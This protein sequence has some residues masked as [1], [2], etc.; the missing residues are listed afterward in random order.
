MMEYDRIVELTDS[1]NTKAYSIRYISPD[2]SLYY[3]RQADRQ[4][5]LYTDGKCEALNHQMFCHFLQMDYEKVCRLYE[6]IRNL[7]NNQI[8]LL[9][10]E[11]N[12]MML[13][14]KASQNRFYYYHYNRALR[15]LERI[16]EEE[17]EFTDRYKERLFYAETEFHLVAA[18]YYIYTMQEQQAVFEL[19]LIDEEGCI[20]KDKALLSRLYYLKGLAQMWDIECEPKKTLEA[21]DHLSFA[22]SQA[23]RSGKMTYL[24]AQT[25]QSL[26]DF[27][28]EPH[29]REIAEQSRTAAF[30]FLYS[31]SLKNDTVDAD[32]P[33]ELQ[34][35]MA[36]ARKG[37]SDAIQCDNL[38]LIANGYY[39][40]GNLRFVQEEYD[41]ALEDYET[42]LS[43]INEHHS[44]YYPNDRSGMLSASRTDDS[45]SVDM[46]WAKD[47]DVQTVPAWLASLRER[48]SATYSALNNKPE[49]DYH[50]NIYLDLLDFTRQDKSLEM[51]VEQV[52]Q[53]NRILNIVLISVIL[54]TVVLTV[55]I[56]YYARLWHKRNLLR[57]N[58]LGDVYSRLKNAM[59]DR[60]E[61]QLNAVLDSYNWMKPEN[62]ILHEVLQ[63]YM[64]WT[65]WNR[66]LS[67]EMDEERTQLRM[68]LMRCERQITKNKRKNISKRAKVSLVYS[69][70]PFIDRIL[71]D[72]HRMKQTRQ[73]N[74]ETLDYIRE[75]T[76]KINAYNDV[77]VE[78]IQMNRGQLE[79]T[80]ESF[81]LQ[82][83]LGLLYKSEYSFHKK[84]L[85]L[86]VHPT[87][88]WVK[89][90]KA[91]TFFMV[92]T[93]ADNARKFTPSGGTVTVSACELD[94]SVEIRVEDTGCGLS[95]E[96]ID[97]ILS[98]KIYDAGKIG[99]C[100]GVAKEEKGSGFG[101]LN[102]K[103]IIE[104]YK[105]SGDMFRVCRF[106]ITSQLGKGS[107]FSFR[108]PKGMKGWCS[109]VVGMLL[110]TVPV[111]AAGTA[112]EHR[113]ERLLKTAVNYADSVY[114]ANIGG[115]Y[116]YTMQM[117]DSTLKYIN[118]A[119]HQ[120]LP[121]KCRCRE[122]TRL[123]DTA[124]ELEW[125]N[126]EVDADY[127][128]IM[129]LR[130]E[131]AVAALALHDWEVYE[132]NNTH[133]TH[134]YKLLSQDSS[135]EEFYTRQRE[136]RMNLN[137]GIASLIVLLLVFL[138]LIFVIHFRRRLLFRFNV[139]QVLEVHRSMLHIVRKYDHADHI[140][141]IFGELLKVIL[142]EL[143][144][145]HETEGVKI[146]FY[147]NISNTT[148]RLSEGY[149]PHVELTDSH[150]ERCYEKKEE[151]YD[152]FINTQVYPLKVTWEGNEELCI[153]AFAVN[154]GSYRMQK[155]DVIL[156][157]YIIG[158]LSIL[159]YEAVICRYR[160]RENMELAETEK[161][162]AV[163]EENRLRVQNQIL[164]NCLSTIKHESM[165]YP[166][167]I[168]QL[169]CSIDA[170][171]DAQKRMEKIHAL[172]EVAEYYKEIYTLLCAQA[173]RQLMTG[174]FKCEAVDT[175]ILVETWL[176]RT[177]RLAEKKQI[178]VTP[179]ADNEDET[180]KVF[181]DRV[182]IDYM[183]ETLTNECLVRLK[184]TGK[185][186]EL[187]LIIAKD[188][189]FIRFTLSASGRLFDA[190]QTEGLFYPDTTHY[191]YLLCKQIIREH[192][193]LN[194][195]C[196]CRI[197]AETGADGT[198]RIW[199]TLPKLQ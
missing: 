45:I 75:L 4:A 196:G 23:E 47:L 28:I 58:L 126:L 31:N 42:A 107:C 39:T 6:Q 158:Y 127:R 40:L 133:Y 77:L 159:L 179:L 155:E 97:M 167:R 130:N 91:F 10:S 74:R 64:D 51:R 57:F 19:S 71:H 83:I 99:D 67:D 2:S 89:A 87:S 172:T 163:F 150:L 111:V 94:D 14:Q 35:P 9:I 148:E 178:R 137:M 174:F 43:Y 78:W 175:G 44:I 26:A 85:T 73:V 61:S 122:L 15:C 98:S 52:K 69:I 164:D 139:I 118:L 84:G 20:R 135:L 17:K 184:E 56:W 100:H 124:E 86:R 195:F 11:I 104:K 132:Y 169:V 193:K 106:D 30:V 191:P 143:K 37:L 101:L 115:R 181:A 177:R 199:M 59:S 170:E 120:A 48:M 38:L 92:N 66:T 1:L 160:D 27:L 146:L 190:D 110:A 166:S 113:T 65:K 16:D 76:D 138:V 105:K 46:I 121:E 188:G 168:N 185:E 129:A 157:R 161:Q 36:L 93:L 70:T 116:E 32:L 13:Y 88:A 62:K 63:P 141:N 165:Y 154:Y 189:D 131:I 109:A 3:A 117:A 25:A 187:R 176:R 108:L 8:E 60:S 90:D 22:F 180:A 55:C 156:E 114:F 72:A 125:W 119:Y 192:D 5:R 145:L 82:D 194:N 81:P 183:L 80:V 128:L 21:F 197:N 95:P 153:G 142:S 18:T 79:L 173:D 34:I 152:R 147:N 7:T 12:M 103:G 144:E 50:R 49:S 33:M 41:K 151:N 171:Q 149:F 54:L 134:L 24:T 136:T 198:S 140:D 112:E 162:R 29:N 182:L 96:D 123:G 102:C 53:D 68:D 186:E